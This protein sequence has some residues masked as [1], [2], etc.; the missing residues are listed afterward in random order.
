MFQHNLLVIYRSFKRFKSA[1][2]INL[3]GLTAGLA[4][5]FL[6]Y[7]WVNDEWGFDKF[8]A[9][10]AQLFQVMEISSE[11]GKK[12]VHDGTQGLLG[13]S[14]AKDLPEVESAVSMLNLAKEEV[15]L[16]FTFNGRTAQYKGIFATRNFFDVFSFKLKT[17]QPAQL[18]SDRNAVVISEGMAQSMFGSAEAA[19]GKTLECAFFDKKKQMQVSGVFEKL[20]PDN[21]LVFDFVMSYEM[22]LQDLWTNGQKWWN[23][24]ANTYLL[25]KTGTD[26]A[27]F[28]EKIAGFIKKYHP[29]TIFTCFVRQYSSGYLHGTYLD[30][31]QDGGRIAYVHLFSSIA[32][33]ILLIACINFMNLS[34]AKASARLK[35]IGI[36]KAVG[37]SRR[38]L[39]VQ[40]LTEAVLLA[41]LST[42]LAAGVVS[43]LLPYFNELT[44]KQ[45]AV[46][47]SPDLLAAA[48]ILTLLTGF[49][50]GSYPAFYL[51]GFRPIEV[52]K[53]KVRHSVGELFARRGLVVFQFMVS[54]ALIFAV[55]VIYQQVEFVQSK[56]LGYDKANVLYFNKVGAAFQNSEAF[57]AELRQIPGVE[58]A[59]AMT[60]SVVQ[61]NSLGGSSTYGIEWP[62][63][64][65]KDLIDFGIQA[66]DFDLI[67]TLGLQMAEGRSFSREFSDEGSRLLFNET[68]IKVMGLKNPVGQQVVLWNEPKIIAGVVRDFH[69]T[70]LREPI[71][72]MVFRFEPKHANT[73]MVKIKTGE[74]RATLERLGDFYKKFNPGHDFDFRFLDEAYQAQYVSERRVSQLSKYFAGLA[75]LISCLGLFGLATFTAQQRTK[76]IGIR[77]VLGASV[78]G[79]TGLLTK[80]FLKLVI[81]AILIASPLAYFFMDKWLTNFAYHIDIQWWMFVAAAL[82]A[83]IIAFLTVGFESVRAAL[84]N[85]V[86]SL[87]SE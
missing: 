82:I 75:I 29:E 58:R 12:V 18:F 5:V 13:E 80:D 41:T 16:P 52:L 14:M 4:C 22:C 68:A 30:G 79:I 39:I 60:N 21:T 11:G 33:F 84:A 44:G 49:F 85:P 27:A 26:V 63:K 54:L 37:S 83:L 61:K 56:N 76:E 8:H 73:V 7:L 38:N 1:F 72:P 62:G 46:S 25:L 43:V 69:V 17:G 28:N 32:L 86:K 48:G 66:V 59:S 24:G 3:L 74:E 51:S 64:S 55:V 65:D 42:S 10:D 40:F 67:E 6:I 70:S 35:E 50:A 81:I 77:K 20:P 78:A 45:I 23:E 9:R 2:F 87:R 15:P 34:T 57:L 36:K 47:F 71:V 19:V 53:G 31:V